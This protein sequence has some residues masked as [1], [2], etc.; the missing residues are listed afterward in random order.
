MSTPR[1]GRKISQLPTLTS[2]SLDVFVV[3]ISG[4]TTYKLSLDALEDAVINTLSASL[5][6]RIDFL[7]T[8]SS[9]YN[10]F[11]SSINA[12]LNANSASALE[13]RLDELE[14][15]T[16]S[17][18]TTGSNSFTGAITASHFKGDGSAL[19]NVTGALSVAI[20]DEGV[21]KGGV[22]TF[23]FSGSNVVSS[24]VGGV[25][26]VEVKTDNTLL[27]TSSFNS[28]SASV[29]NR[30][31]AATNEQSFNGLI[32]GSSQLTASYDERYA[33]S[34]SITTNT[35]DVTF[36]GIK[37]IGAGTGSGDGNGYSTLEMVPD[38][39]LYGGDQYIILDPTGPNHI[40]IRPGGTIDNSGADLY[41]GGEKHYVRVSDSSPSVRMQ[42]E[43]TRTINSYYFS[44]GF[45]AVSIEWYTQSG[46]HY[47]RF[48]DPTMDVYNA[49]WAFNSP[50]T[51]TATYNGGADYISFTV[52]GSSTPGFPQS[53]SF[54]VAEA[55][56]S[57]PTYLDTV[58]I[59]ILQ[60]RESYVSIQNRDIS[61]N[62][63]DDL[64]LYSRDTFSLRNYSDTSPIEI[65]AN[66]DNSDK[67]FAFNPDGTLTFPD[68]TTQ[69]T[70]FTG[71]PENLIS[72]SS[73]L[74]SSLDTRYAASGNAPT[75]FLLEAYANE[76]Y[77][78]PG[79]F[80]EDPCRYSVVS[81]NE[82][83]PSN[84]FN[85]STYR[86][87]PQKAGYWEINACYDVYRNSEASM[88]I[89]KNGSIV[90]SAGSFNAV[91]Q[92]VIKIVYL[93]GSTDYIDIVNTGGGTLQRYQYQQRSWFQAKWIGQ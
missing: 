29:N 28:F 71:L 52:N 87:T 72:G 48:N 19:T 20:L 5:D 81:V 9:S 14:S 32:S 75:L 42:T 63:D 40:H 8:F 21:Y 76:T 60:N 55:P 36:D 1:T 53:P 39:S 47:V 4:E 58:D 7:E 2:A 54:Y 64:R 56:P 85:T 73:Q 50:S 92:Q 82:N 83:V 45:G 80:T 17:Y 25:A 23:N 77:T 59:Q 24:I 70:S 22:T 16:G 41:I 44:P 3:G 78:L 49:I 37:V 6:N 66:Y 88:A 26:L 61:I 93:N 51:F 74:T 35:G 11:S 12:Q 68:G 79:G 57:S 46:N 89:R 34:G 13:F 27:S 65:V 43:S 62:A 15:K 38:N 86:F 33:L 90:A 30:I 69:T 31:I 10:Q 84:W 67:I 18:A 91:A